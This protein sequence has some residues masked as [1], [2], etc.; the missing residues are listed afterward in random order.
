[1][2][3]KHV[4]VIELYSGAVNITTKIGNRRENA[5]VKDVLYVPGLRYNLFSIQR[6]G[7]LGMQVVFRKNS[8]EILKSGEVVCTGKRKD[9]LFELNVDVSRVKEPAALVTENA[10]SNEELWHRRF[11]HI[12][13]SGLVK[14]VSGEMVN[15]L[16]LKK[17][18][19]VD[20][21]VCEPCLKGKQTRKP[22]ME[23]PLPRSSRPLEVIHSDVCG[24]MTPAAY[25]GK[26][27]FVSFTDDCTHFTAVYMLSTKDEVLEAF[28]T[29]AAMAESHF[30]SRISRLRCDNGGEYVGEKFRSFCR[31]KGIQLEYTVP[32]TPQQ[33][34]VSERLNRTIM[35]KARAMIEDAGLSKTL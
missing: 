24:A 11:G 18:E 32:Y 20:R 29:Y 9:K 14:I 6:V 26:R 27:Y 23:M 10:I 12:G 34:G 22:F 17:S 2:K 7:L 28:E 19:I 31:R 5:V 3:H 35:D 16:N 15:G 33:N 4:T 21:A 25:N 13:R 30:D 1:M 8:V